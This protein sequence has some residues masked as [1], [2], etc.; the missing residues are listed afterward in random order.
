M[1]LAES[2]DEIHRIIAA[3]LWTGEPLSVIHLD[4]ST[5]NVI[6]ND[7]IQ[8]KFKHKLQVFV[9]TADAPTTLQQVLYD[10]KK[11]QWWNH[12]AFY[13]ILE[14]PRLESECSNAY[15]M[16]WTAW[17]MDILNA[18]YMCLNQSKGLSIYSYNPYTSDAPNSW[19][20][21]KTYRVKNN[22]P[23]TLF[24]RNYRAESA[25]A[26]RDLDF[27]KTSNVGGHKI[28]FLNTNVKDLFQIKRNK[29]NGRISFGGFQGV[30]FHTLLHY[31]KATPKMILLPGQHLDGTLVTESNDNITYEYFKNKKIDLMVN[32]YHLAL[33][34]NL[35][36]V[37]PFLQSG[38]RVITQFSG[39]Q[40]Q[41]SKIR[42]VF[43]HYSRLGLLLVSLT[44]AIF[45]KYYLGQ[46]VMP[47]FLNYCRLICNA[48]LPRLPKK[49]PGRIYLSG[50]F[51]FFLIFQG[52]FQ[53]KLSS[54]LTKD[55]HRPNINTM[56]DLAHG[57]YTIYG[58]TKY[59]HFF[60]DQRFAERFVETEGYNC[61]KYVLHD[62][63]AACVRDDMLL[64]YD[65]SG[66]HLH[67][68]SDFIVNLYFVCGIRDDWPLEQRTNTFYER[69]VQSGLINYLKKKLS[70]K[71]LRDLEI[72]EYM[73]E[74]QKIKVITL[75]QLKFIFVILGFGLTL[76]TANFIVECNI[77]RIK[78]LIHRVE[79]KVVAYLNP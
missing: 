16:L 8:R 53:G 78:T 71:P 62:S 15:E 58:Q 2:S 4:S 36:H 28:R 18:K 54:L 42:A 75:Q 26:F 48:S 32:Y 20:L 64:I 41:L 19:K 50:I 35:S 5:K 7:S 51:I 73:Y 1:G 27:D 44:T 13:L 74:N 47:S 70:A 12:M 55:V 3:K 72:R 21:V 76:A 22:H 43:D 23:W 11:S 79:K 49:V 38:L 69:M 66:L 63:L 33:T 45:F 25:G 30:I 52:I 6:S 10:I 34:G 37:Y 39:E 61:T 14:W 9:V 31:I 17:K 46:I 65:A 56:S 57:K 77:H 60:E 24:V 29:K 67:L 59:H 68:S 40:S